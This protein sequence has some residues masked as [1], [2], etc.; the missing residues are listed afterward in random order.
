MWMQVIK[1]KW[2]VGW[3]RGIGS[4]KRESGP[5]ENETEEDKGINWAGQQETV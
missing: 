3:K 5:E 1:G 2:R 4:M